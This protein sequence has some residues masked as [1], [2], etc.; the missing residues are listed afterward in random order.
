MK[1]L[2]TILFAALLFSQG[3]SAQKDERNVK[4]F[5][6]V[7]AGGPIDVVIKF[8]DKESLMFEGDKEAIATLV[9][10]V[11][12]DKLVIRPQTSWVSWARKYENKKITAYVTA[13][14]L[15]SLAM[16]GNGSITVSGTITAAEFAVT[17]SGSGSIKANVEADKITGILSGSGTSNISGK[18]GEAS[19]ILSGPGTFGSKL[20][21]VNDLSAKI[22]GK[23]NVY[24][25]TEG[26]INAFI[27]GSGHV[28]YTG[29]ADV[30]KTVI[31][32]GG[33]SK[34]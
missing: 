3:A 22:S 20:L 19:I 25:S 15:S 2:F 32:S 31:G 33:V 29:N 24:I 9:S 27:T 5:N 18:A 4:N 6:G 14:Q 8:G 21:T 13:K 16:S 26:K 1:L 10:E 7:V 34:L 12:G 23:G 11:K 28:F 30:E 17:L